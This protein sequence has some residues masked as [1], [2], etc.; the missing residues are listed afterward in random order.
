MESNIA[1]IIT[2]VKSTITRYFPVSRSTTV[3]HAGG[4]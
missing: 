3:V 1:Y 2:D 4:V